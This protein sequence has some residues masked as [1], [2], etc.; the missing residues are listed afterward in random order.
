MCG[1]NKRGSADQ[2]VDPGDAYK[3]I[4]IWRGCWKIRCC[5]SQLFIVPENRGGNVSL[6]YY[7]V[8]SLCLGS[9]SAD[10][11]KNVCYGISRICI[12]LFECWKTNFCSRKRHHIIQRS[13]S[14][15]VPNR[16]AYDVR[17]HRSFF[18]NNINYSRWIDAS[19]GRDRSLCT[20]REWIIYRLLGGL[21]GNGR[22]TF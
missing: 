16:M 2:F 3:C 9:I 21:L 14:V 20:R 5:E 10:N 13:P 15:G 4:T 22:T 6:D 19:H 12:I 18:F 8:L 17:C 11:C 7:M 1:H